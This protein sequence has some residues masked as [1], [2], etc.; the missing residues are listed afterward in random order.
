[1]IESFRRNN[2]REHRQPYDRIDR[3]LTGIRRGCIVTLA[4]LAVY[5]AVTACEREEIDTINTETTTPPPHDSRHTDPVIPAEGT[6]GNPTEKDL[7]Q[8]EN[9]RFASRG[10]NGRSPLSYMDFTHQEELRAELPDR[11]YACIEMPYGHKLNARVFGFDEK[12]VGSI[13]YYDEYF[14]EAC[15][16]AEQSGDVQEY[17]TNYFDSG[18]PQLDIFSC[19]KNGI[20]SDTLS[21]DIYRE[22]DDF[23]NGYPA[24]YTEKIDNFPL[25]EFIKDNYLVSEYYGNEVDKF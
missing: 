1:M 13:T 23:T 4:G 10:D 15:A 19:N 21:W 7:E 20:P 25:C 11:E 24:T 17:F 16:Q 3:F 9:S 12:P 6:Y 8:N 18:N 2:G 22:G 5:G 14:S